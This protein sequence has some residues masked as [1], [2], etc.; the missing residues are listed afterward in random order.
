[1]VGS[2]NGHVGVVRL[3]LDTEAIDPSLQKEV[4]LFM[5]GGAT[6]VPLRG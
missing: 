1:M 4:R 5:I 2:Q 3:L 6:H